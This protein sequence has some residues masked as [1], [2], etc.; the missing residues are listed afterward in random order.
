MRE[1]NLHFA[2]WCRSC[3]GS[4]ECGVSGD[5]GEPHWLTGSHKET[6]AFCFFCFYAGRFLNPPKAPAETEPRPKSRTLSKTTGF[7]ERAAGAGHQREKFPFFFFFWVD[8]PMASNTFAFALQ[9]YQFERSSAS[10]TI[11]SVWLQLPDPPCPRLF[12]RP[13][14]WKIQCLQFS[15]LPKSWGWEKIIIIFLQIPTSLQEETY[16]LKLEMRKTG[17]KQS[18]WM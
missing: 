13:H 6:G 16:L 18:A 10:C 5:H 2:V 9:D 17:N 11:E 4:W 14:V 7:T 12:S 1:K 15:L 8:E 3:K